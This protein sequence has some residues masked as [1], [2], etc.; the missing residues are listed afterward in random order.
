MHSDEG[1]GQSDVFFLVAA[2]SVESAGGQVGCA[3]F[4]GEECQAAAGRPGLGGVRQLARDAAS[5]QAGGDGKLADVGVDLPGEMRLLAD[6][7]HASDTPVR[8]RHVDRVARL[9][10]GVERRFNPA[11]DSAPHCLRISPGRDTFR[12]AW[13]EGEDPGMVAGLH[14]ADL[15]TLVFG[16]VATLAR[17]ACVKKPPVLAAP[18]VSIAEFGPV[19][20]KVA[21]SAWEVEPSNMYAA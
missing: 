9:T 1:L 18:Q 19:R 13:R 6:G 10:G 3:G 5:L 7:H 8:D 12:E 14:R 15:N 2:A 21:L 16:H 20:F 4:Q 11:A 17:D